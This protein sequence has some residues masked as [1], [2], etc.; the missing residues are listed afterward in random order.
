MIPVK[1]IDK[2]ALA[3]LKKNST[4]N[5]YT[6]VYRPADEIVEPTTGSEEAEDATG[7]SLHEEYEDG[8]WKCYLCGNVNYK[9]QN[10]RCNMRNCRAPR[11][12]NMPDSPPVAPRSIGV[13]TKEEAIAAAEAEAEEL[14]RKKAPKRVSL[15]ANQRP[16]KKSKKR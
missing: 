16:Q 6:Y 9:H 15:Y 10:K 7:P 4:P 8:R 1:S 11:Y 5:P 14:A 12:A 3:A 13:T 2:D